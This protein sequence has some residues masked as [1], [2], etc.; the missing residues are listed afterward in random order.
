MIVPNDFNP[1]LALRKWQAEAKTASVNQHYDNAVDLVAI[2][3]SEW[4]NDHYK[5][6]DSRAKRQILT[7]ASASLPFPHLQEIVAHYPSRDDW[8]KRSTAGMYELLLAKL[9][10]EEKDKSEQRKREHLLDQRT[11]EHVATHQDRSDQPASLPM[12]QRPRDSVTGVIHGAHVAPPTRVKEIAE[13]AK[14]VSEASKDL[15][16]QLASC[17]AENAVLR[18]EVDRWKAKAKELQAE[19]AKVQR[20]VDRQQKKIDTQRSLRG[21]L[22]PAH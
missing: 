15:A 8:G 12:V 9:A 13:H 16:T 10:K 7:D 3:E 6:L 18:A 2:Y 19:L 20:L 11:A 4:F 21:G 14:I 22:Q 17:H 5:T 1:R